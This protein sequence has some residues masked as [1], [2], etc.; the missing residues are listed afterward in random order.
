[1]N[2]PGKQI[3]FCAL[4]VGGGLNGYNQKGVRMITPCGIGASLGIQIAYNA[5]YPHFF[6]S[7]IIESKL[8]VFHRP[9]K[10]FLRNFHLDYLF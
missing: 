1:M 8:I 3:S 2:P 7:L 6:I 9:Y 5:S 10:S 4:V